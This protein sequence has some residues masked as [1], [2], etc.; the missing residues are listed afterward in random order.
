MPTRYQVSREDYSDPSGWVPVGKFGSLH[1]AEAD[2]RMRERMNPWLYS[3][4]N[5]DRM[6]FLIEAI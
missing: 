5:P 2:A 1:K 6:Y 3:N 4:N